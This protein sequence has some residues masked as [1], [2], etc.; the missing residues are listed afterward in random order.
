MDWTRWFKVK[1]EDREFMYLF[2]GDTKKE[3]QPFIQA[4]K[5]QGDLYRITKEKGR[6][7]I[8]DARV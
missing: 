2:E 5:G 7:F 8:Y 6:Y 1:G 3:L 4:V